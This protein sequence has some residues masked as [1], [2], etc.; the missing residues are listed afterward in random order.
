MTKW[1]TTKV[2]EEFLK[3]FEAKEHTIVASS[4]LLPA[5]DKTLLFTNAGMNQFKNLFLGQEVRSYTRATTSQ[6]CVRAGGKH[7][8][9]EN[10][11]FT[12]RHHTFF[13]MLGNFSFGDYFK[14]DAIKFAWE[15]ITEVFGLAKERLFVTVYKDD[16]EA[17]A[18]WRDI[19]NV[20]E[21]HI[22]KLGEKDNFWAMG[23]TGPCGPCSEIHYDM[24]DNYTSRE[25]YNGDEPDWDC[26]RFVEIWNLVFMQYNRDETGKM[27]PLPKPSIDTG[28]GLERITA[29]LNGVKSNYEIDVFVELID[30]IKNTLG[31]PAEGALEASFRVI[32][33]HARATSFLIADSIT[34]SNEGRGYVLR[35]IMR[36]AIRHGHRLGFSGIFFHEVCMKL[37]DIMGNHYNELINQKELIRNIVF[38]EEKRFRATLDKGLA[39]LNDGIEEAK[40]GGSNELSGELVFKLYDTYG[41]PSDLTQTILDEVGFSFSKEGYDEAMKA[42]QERGKASWST[43]LEEKKVQTAQLLQE[44]GIKEIVFE[45]YSKMELSGQVL[46]IIDEKF[47]IIT[48]ALPNE[49]VYLVMNPLVFYAESGGQAGDTGLVLNGETVLGDVTDCIKIGEIRAAKV[50][51]K[52]PISKGISVVQTVDEDRRNAIRKNHSA[53]HLLHLALKEVVGGHANQ[54]GSLVNVERLRF[55]F[56]HYA[57]LTKEELL[58]IENKVNKMIQRNNPVSTVV[59]TI[60]EA[61]KDGATALFGEKYG[62]TVSVVSMGE[63]KE[64]CGGTH[65]SAT[66]DIGLFKI[67]KEEGIAAGVRRIEAATGMNAVHLFQQMESTIASAAS[68][69]SSEKALLIPTVEKTR[70]ELK[71]KNKQIEEL[72]T[73]IS[74]LEAANLKP[75]L[76]KDGI[77]IYIINS[78]KSRS[79]I[80]ALADSLKSKVHDGLFF[81]TGIDAD[82]GVAV[83]AASGKAK[84]I[85]DAGKLL[86]TLLA[87]FGGKGG[88]R[89]DMAQGGAAN[90]DF[91]IWKSKVLEILG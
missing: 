88:G 50:A 76:E 67:I 90:I 56:N 72:Q 59:K 73:K 1:T 46:A 75:E 53:T 83:V 22:F 85:Y 74:S 82:K 86:G 4:P 32:A 58:E 41:F 49:T 70:N 36:R 62:E 11:G 12:D 31:K 37:I 23:D 28:M 63:S 81:I 29:A 30:F 80:T 52:M 45:G 7:N 26:G 84:E 91:N 34:P 66:G 71:A 64:L 47:D 44:E 14:V 39:L 89:K 68:L 25:H 57:A 40:K 55:D 87:H 9:L 17:L 15:L 16:D 77:G 20:P 79:E 33:D 27:T 6:K 19:M 61:K 10:V 5:E 48:T 60:D 8:D 51:V 65:V 42:Q 69:L 24:W 43:G 2:R 13:E 54:A 3:Y 35:R 38:E 21:N 78:G 18:I